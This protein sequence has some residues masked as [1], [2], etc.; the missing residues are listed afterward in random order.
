MA[1]GS[2]GHKPRL[3]EAGGKKQAAREA[4]LAEAMRL[5]LKRRKEQLR[6]LAEKRASRDGHPS[7]TPEG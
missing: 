2:G 4:R 5:N 1:D 3:T 7:K 6:G